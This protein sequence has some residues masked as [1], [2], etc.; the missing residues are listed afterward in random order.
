MTKESLIKSVLPPVVINFLLRMRQPKITRLVFPDFSQAL[1]ACKNS[2]Q[3]RE[4]VDVVVEK[5]QIY[6][7]SLKQNN[8]IDLGAL[9]PV[10]AMGSILKDNKL[11]VIDFGGG[12]GF[13]FFIV[14]KI[15]GNN[16]KLKWNVVETELMAQAAEA[17][18]STDDLSF[19]PN[20]P[21]AVQNLGKV[22]LVY[23]SSALQYCPDPYE[24]LRELV[25]I[26]AK[27]LFITR[28]PFIDEDK[29][30]VTVQSSQLADNGPGPLPKKHKNR[31][32]LYPITYAS[33]EEVE[34]ILSQNYVIQYQTK[35][36][37]TGFSFKGKKINSNGY[38][39]EL[40]Q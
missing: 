6:R 30:M 38:F 4:L 32:L 40:K 31:Q 29:Q 9:R 23:T 7:D 22:D 24:V 36:S 16:F 20:I 5:N 37:D 13:H 2:Y 1:Q 25:S 21:D 34:K 14:K 19:S 17:T 18:L 35:E 12:G 26:R 8:L 28:T 15:L 11:N 33:R 27:Y 39:C 10:I 3:N